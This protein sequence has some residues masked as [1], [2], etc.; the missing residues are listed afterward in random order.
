M[1][2]PI[3]EQESVVLVEIAVVE[4]EQKFRAVRIE[5]LDRMRDTGPEIPQI[6]D[7]DVVDEIAPV[8]VDRGD[9]RRAGEHVGPFGGLVP[10]QL[11]NAAG[12]EPHVHAGN[13]FG[14]AEFARRDLPG[15]A[16]GFEAHVRVFEGEAEVRQRAVVGRRRRQHVGVL[17][18]ANWILRTGIA[19]AVTGTPRLRHGFGRLRQRRRRQHA[20]S[21]GRSQ[22]IS[23]RNEFGDVTHRIFYSGL[24]YTART[25]RI[26]D[27]AM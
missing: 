17:A 3:G 14:D 20:A 24:S 12:I 16:G 10:M 22:H 7:A 23:T 13:V 26:V 15:P 27:V 11:T 1:L 8:G 19:A 18:S 21:G 2:D 4:H 6:A 9:A 5:T 25:R